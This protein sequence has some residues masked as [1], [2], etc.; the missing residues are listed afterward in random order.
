M[1]L[2][3]ILVVSAIVC[4]A[5]IPAA[6]QERAWFLT[7]NSVTEVAV[8]NGGR[9]WTPTWR[10]A[11]PSHGFS[12]PIATLGGRYLVWAASR[13]TGSALV[14]LDTRTR[15]VALFPG[16][17]PFGVW[18]SAIERRTGLLVVLDQSA[19]YLLDVARLAVVSRHPLPADDA[20]NRS[21]AIA[22]QRAFVGTKTPSRS[23]TLV[24]NVW[25]GEQIAVIPDVW[26]A[27]A[28]R[29]EG[30]IYLQTVGGQTQVRNV[31]TLAL[32]ASAANGEVPAAHV[33]GN[34]LVSETPLG[35]SGMPLEIRAYDPRTLDVMFAADVP[36]PGTPNALVELQQAAY[37]SP[38]VLR[39]H[40]C[41]SLWG[42]DLCN[43]TIQ[44]FDA[45]TLTPVRELRQLPFDVYQSRMVL[46]AR[47]EPPLGLHPWVVDGSRIATL[48]WVP[49]PDIG[50]YEIVVGSGPGRSDVAVFRTQVTYV[51]FDGVPPGTYY[52]R[53][54]AL[55]EIGATESVE[56]RVYVA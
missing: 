39:T 46:L 11:L 49:P 23:E 7:A 28:S 17:V 36:I 32:I 9:E 15:E 3:R 6:A 44:V 5:A 48:S 37:A 33:V 42:P 10:L 2:C 41:Y 35:P 38:I 13:E 40:N 56:I 45:R 50:E 52:I 1:R 21:L 19:L 53:V 25:T 26:I 34:T 29:D 24:L 30:L 12:Q 47:P 31:S 55:N 20:E 8:T 51:R 27:H 43:R 4:G 22:Q 14:R 16:V 54:R 18:Q